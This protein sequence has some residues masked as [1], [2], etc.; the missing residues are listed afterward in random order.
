[1]K[2]RKFR[3]YWRQGGAICLCFWGLLSSAVYAQIGPPPNIVVQP[4]NVIVTNQGTATFSVKI[5]ANATP[6]SYAWRYRKSENDDEGGVSGSGGSGTVY[7]PLGSATITFSCNNAKPEDAGYYFVRLKNGSGTIVSSNAALGVIGVP[8]QFDL[9][10]R[11][12]DG[13]KLRLKGITAPTYVIEAS[14]NT[15]NWT[16]IST[17]SGASGTVT[18]TDPAGTNRDLRFYRARI[19]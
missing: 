9:A 4:S 7:S 3:S 1:M 11:V 19:Q 16:A 10:Q 15:V 2:Y 17:N 6:I 8:L 5:S 12:S 14:S 13:F 18:Y